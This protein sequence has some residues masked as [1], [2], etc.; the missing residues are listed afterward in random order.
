MNLKLISVILFSF[1]VL[2]GLVTLTAVVQSKKS[3]TRATFDQ[4]KAIRE[5]QSFAIET[6]L[7]MIG[8]TLK[9]IAAQESTVAAVE[10]FADAF[11]NYDQ[12]YQI[13]DTLVTNDLTKNYNNEYL[14]NVN[15]NI[16][17]SSQKKEIKKY[18][19][20]AINGRLLQHT[21]I[22]SNP[23]PVGAKEKLTQTEVISPYNTAHRT[24]HHSL[25][26]VMNEFNFYDIFLTDTEGN[27]IYTV[28]KE[29]DFATNLTNDIYAESGLGE[30]FKKLK[31][32]KKGELAF[33]DFRPYE[34][35]YN[36]PAAFLGT[37]VS[38]NGKI[39]GYMIVQLP[40]EI[41]NAISDFGGKYESVGMGKTGLT[42]LLGS[43]M[44]MRNN[45]RFLDK[46]KKDNPE[47]ETAGTS[48]G[49][50]KINSRAAGN[51]VAGQEG[52][53]I[54]IS[55][56]GEKSFTA[57]KPL[58]V[59]GQTWGIIVKKDYAEALTEAWQLRN[60]IIA[61]SCIIT[62]IALALT[63]ILLRRMVISKINQLTK[64]TKNIATGEGDLTLRIPVKGHDE[65]AELS[66][67]FNQFIENVQHIVRDVQKSADS[68]SIG[69]SALASTTEELNLTF[70]EQAE[71]VS[72]VASAM[73]ELNSTTTEIS[74][75]SMNALDK[76]RESGDITAEGKV[77][78]EESVSKIQD[79]ME[80]TKLLGETVSNLAGSSAKIAEI[81]N[82]INDIADQT[83][84]LALN[85]AIEAARA[86]E[87]GRGFAVVADE[88]RKLAERTQSAT[89][90]I[91]GIISEFK[92]ETASA[93]RNMA[94]AETSVNEGVSIMGKTSSVFDNIVCSVQEIETANSSINNA[95][96][97]QITTLNSVT[98][99]VQ[100][101]ASSVEQSSN[102]INDVT[103]TLAEQDKQTEELK[104][105]V[106]RFK[107]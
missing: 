9:S 75:S 92:R 84:L 55:G 44:Y 91:D 26:E 23:N 66:K 102:A 38:A 43:D 86:G 76:A 93:S 101:I 57:Y 81:V 13:S 36:S 7:D 80:Q 53:E 104:E 95:I 100:G 15:Y 46:L 63:I 107:V 87:A 67:Y 89:S 58:D 31:P 79:I 47:V 106:N 68:V 82:V 39:T 64:I 99:E 50:V 24:Y 83:N 78:I 19:P 65:I 61:I 96:S 56:M 69:T 62:I 25:Y 17:R 16:P 34:P 3:L 1:I 33:A 90:E 49:I 22:Y 74:D 52:A 41:I 105:M 40:V 4:L 14:P 73:E 37:P 6:Y 59:Y 28:Y 11:S 51:S 60:L 12:Y 10:E 97:E 98:T 2:S 8:D 20:S 70:N 88:V 29:K 103:M 48:V 45:H 71:N 35:S 94:S 30:V 85:A 18:L 72:S 77:K 27:V 21:Y 54:I 32:L 42:V 5:T